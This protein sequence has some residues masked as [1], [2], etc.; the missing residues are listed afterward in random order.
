LL[1]PVKDAGAI[2]DA[3]QKMMDQSTR[4]DLTDE[5]RR[6]AKERFSLESM[7]TRYKDVYSQLLK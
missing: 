1:V 2:V 5:A 4:K 7:L 6:T 3:I